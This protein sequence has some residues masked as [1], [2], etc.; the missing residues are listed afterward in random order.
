M[1]RSQDD[2]AGPPELQ[3]S[4]GLAPINVLVVEDDQY[5]KVAIS[6]ILER[7][8][9]QAGYAVTVKCVETG[10]FALEEAKSQSRDGQSFDLVLMDY[11]LLAE[12]GQPS[13]TASAHLPA[14]RAQLGP[15]AAIVMLSTSEQEVQLARCLA[16]G[17][18]A[19]RLKPISAATVHELLDYAREKRD[20]LRKRRRLLSASDAGARHSAARRTERETADATQSGSPP[21]ASASTST[22]STPSAAPRGPR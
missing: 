10:H 20:F 11:I 13:R 8:G 17:A 3:K 15:T 9:R 2:E 18:D 1:K 12:H 16:L 22:T 21:R 5:Q 4:G 19:Y 6:W 14:L 7:T